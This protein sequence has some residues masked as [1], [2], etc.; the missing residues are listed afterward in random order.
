MIKIGDI[1]VILDKT[2]T[3]GGDTCG[4]RAIDVLHT[5]IAEIKDINYVGNKGI[6]YVSVSNIGRVGHWWIVPDHVVKLSQNESA[7]WRRKYKLADGKR[8]LPC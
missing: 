3:D 1:V 4:N 7:F 8:E 2:I 6:E 5:C